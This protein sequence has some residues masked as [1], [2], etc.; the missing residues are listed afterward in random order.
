MIQPDV[1]DQYFKAL[2]DGDRSACTRMVQQL[3]DS[4]IDIKTLYRQLFEKSL[5]QVGELWESN[6]ISVAREHLV[7]AITENLL[8]L[9]YPYLFKKRHLSKKAVISCAANEYHQIGGKM[10]ADIFEM[11]GWDSYFLGA[12]TPV[13]QMVA[14]IH[15][16][17]P[18]LV[19]LSLSIYFNLPSLEKGLDAITT[20]FPT[21]DII[22]GGQAFRWGE[23]TLLN[24][25]KQV[26][27][28]SSLDELEQQLKEENDA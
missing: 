24:R 2:L 18:D 1:Y 22:V 10:V 27:Y 17:R 23:I 15:E 9:I 6:Q 19:G 11:S 25:F 12:N 7:T 13:D 21:L 16:T 3:L 20:E 14:F 8:N 26:S 4:G 5:Y 28:L